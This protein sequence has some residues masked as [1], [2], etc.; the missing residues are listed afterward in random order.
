MLEQARKYDI[1]LDEERLVET[2]RMRARRFHTVI[3]P[4]FRLLGFT[5]GLSSIGLYRLLDPAPADWEVFGRYVAVYYGYAFLTWRALRAYYGK[6]KVDISL[7]FLCFDIPFIVTV[8]YATGAESSWLFCFLMVRVADQTN[9]T[10]RRVASFAHLAIGCYIVMLLYVQFVDGRPIPWTIEAAKIVAMYAINF[11]VALTAKTAEDMRLRAGQAFKFARSLILELAEKSK[12]TE[13]AMGRAESANQAKSD[14]LAN[15]SHEIRTPINGILGMTDL[16]LSTNVNDEQ[17]LYLETVKSSSDALLN[18]INEILDFSKIEAGKIELEHVR[19]SLHEVIGGAMRTI[20]PQAHDKNLELIYR[21]DP[22]AGAFFV[23]DPGRIRQIVLNVIGNAVKFTAEGEVEIVVRAGDPGEP[24]ITVSVRDTGIGISEAAR[25]AI[26]QAFEQ[27][28]GSTT[29]RF[30]GTGLG[31]SITKKFVEMMGGTIDVESEVGAGSVFRFSMDLERATDEE[32]VSAGLS[33]VHPTIVFEP[34][35]AMGEAVLAQL[36]AIGREAVLFDD[37][38]RWFDAVR[39]AHPLSVALY[40]LTG[41]DEDLALGARVLT[42]LSRER[43]LVFVR[44]PAGSPGGAALPPGCESAAVLGKPF[45]PIELGD[46]IERAEQ[47][48]AAKSAP[49]PAAPARH[50]ASPAPAAAVWEDSVDSAATVS[51]PRVLV[52]EDNAVNQL[53]VKK[54]LE[55]LGCLPSMAANGKEALE[56]WQSGDFALILMDIQMPIMDG[57]EAARSIR[58]SESAAGEGAP[59]P[60]VAVTANAMKGDQEACLDAGMNGYIAKP[61]DRGELERELARHLETAKPRD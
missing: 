42:T 44:R 39:E 48:G 54:M 17:R 38:A 24:R 40:S 23:G 2:R 59:I 35:R 18:I 33:R 52:A 41:R 22:A 3:V 31:L 56:R 12:E 57:F 1:E 36:H 29:R 10:F 5:L 60:I 32:S 47:A 21:P 30:G 4:L 28:D 55:S 49:P 25:A 45:T 14:I 27:A 58:E 6:T 34:H 20:A 9:T 61:I 19:F 43:A 15:M 13:L 7:L 26:F 46:A 8:I 50:C 51:G 53:V 37:P 16:T 11:Y